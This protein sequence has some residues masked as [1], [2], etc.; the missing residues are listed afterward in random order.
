MKEVFPTAENTVGLLQKPADQGCVTGPGGIYGNGQGIQPPNLF[1]FQR[2]QQGHIAIVLHSQIVEEVVKA[3]LIDF[4]FLPGQSKPAQ[5][6]AEIIETAPIPLLLLRICRGTAAAG[7][8]PHSL[9][10]GR[11]AP[12]PA[13]QRL[14]QAP[15]P[16][17]VVIKSKFFFQFFRISPA[18]GKLFH[19]LPGT[20]GECDLPGTACPHSQTG[21]LKTVQIG[22]HPDVAGQSPE[23]R[24]Y[25]VR[26]PD[27]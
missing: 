24:V 19:D 17:A 22:F 13:N 11:Q 3:L 18:V 21:L 27:M 8:K 15:W 7:T 4:H 2:L 1:I 20:A 16:K 12:P 9:S 14:R 23:I 25:P 5:I 10:A 6:P 26:D